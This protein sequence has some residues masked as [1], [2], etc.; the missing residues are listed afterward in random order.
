[1]SIKNREEAF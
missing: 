1:S